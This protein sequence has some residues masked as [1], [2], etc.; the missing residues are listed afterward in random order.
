MDPGR[1]KRDPI[2][3]ME[4]GFLFAGRLPYGESLRGKVRLSLPLLDSLL[5]R[6]LD[7]WPSTGKNVKCQGLTPPII[8]LTG[9]KGILA[10]PSG[11]SGGWSP[12]LLN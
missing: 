8:F 11:L 2:S 7:H 5:G 4:W 10:E 12:N 3:E 1:K 9:V 6:G